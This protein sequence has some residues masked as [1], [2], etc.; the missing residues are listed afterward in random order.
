M[1]SVRY[2]TYLLIFAEGTCLGWLL[3]SLY[4]L[5]SVIRTH[6][7]NF[8]RCHTATYFDTPTDS[9][10]LGFLFPCLLKIFRG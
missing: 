4:M 9:N 10:T 8:P 1:M 6:I 3:F 7:V 5:S 2:V